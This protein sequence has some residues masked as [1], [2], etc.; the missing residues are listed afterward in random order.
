MK[1]DQYLLTKL[2]E[3]CA[4][5][6]HAACKILVHGVNNFKPGGTETN[7]AA[8]VREVDDLMAVLDMWNYKIDVARVKIKQAKLEAEYVASNKL[9]LAAATEELKQ[10]LK[11]AA[12]GNPMSDEHPMS[13]TQ[14]TQGNP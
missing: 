2:I 13:E 7:A 9:A 8:L 10:Q 1:R 14:T 5:V 11:R 3:E 12:R 6:Q 4:E